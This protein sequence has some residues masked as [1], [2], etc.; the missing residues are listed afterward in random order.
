MRQIKRNQDV[1]VVVDDI[2]FNE[3]FADVLV[4]EPLKLTPE[5]KEQLWTDKDSIEVYRLGTY[6]YAQI[7]GCL[8]VYNMIVKEDSSY[9]DTAHLLGNLIKNLRGNVEYSQETKLGE[10]SS[11]L[12]KLIYALIIAT[13]DGSNIAEELWK[14]L[15]NN[16]N[17]SEAPF[18]SDSQIRTLNDMFNPYYGLGDPVCGKIAS[19]V[20]NLISFIEKQYGNIK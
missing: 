11:P 9:P 6:Q 16:S 20:L 15:T 5:E 2:P 19:M 18:I 13:Q 14:Y 4:P 8:R 12:L 10:K 1:F 7:V 3:L 17:I